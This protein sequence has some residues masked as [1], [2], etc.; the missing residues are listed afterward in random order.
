MKLTVLAQEF[1]AVRLSLQE[2]REIKQLGS[3]F[4]SMLWELQRGAKQNT[5]D[6]HVT[7]VLP[8]FS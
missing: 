3:L 6:G 4:I 7:K 1:C 5:N 2:D 8:E